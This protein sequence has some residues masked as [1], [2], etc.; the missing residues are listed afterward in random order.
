MEFEEEDEGE[1]DN[2][3]NLGQYYEET[4]VLEK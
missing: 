4:E 2:P 3:G 1:E